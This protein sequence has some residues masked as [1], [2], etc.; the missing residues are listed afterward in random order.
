MVLLCFVPYYYAHLAFWVG[1]AT[2]TADAIF[3]LNIPKQLIIRFPGPHGSL[4]VLNLQP[5]HCFYSTLGAGSVL[6]RNA[7]IEHG[8]GLASVVVGAAIYIVQRQTNYVLQTFLSARIDDMCLR[9][10]SCRR[11]SS[12]SASVPVPLE[13]IERPQSESSDDTMPA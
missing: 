4:S 7:E 11:T 1:V 9:R 2:L 8:L 5:A 13:R 10:S 3:A 12:D 6:D